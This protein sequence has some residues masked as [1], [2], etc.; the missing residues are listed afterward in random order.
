MHWNPIMPRAWS[1][2]YR[3]G[4]SSI[5]RFAIVLLLL[6]AASLVWPSPAPQAA[7]NAVPELS[8]SLQLDSSLRATSHRY[9]IHIHGFQSFSTDADQRAVDDFRNF[10]PLAA[11]MLPPG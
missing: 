5:Y 10:A 3:P 8:P 6:L 2:P 1:S 11:A 9:L 4:R 7:P